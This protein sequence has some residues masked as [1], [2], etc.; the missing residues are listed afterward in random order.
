MI[1]IYEDSKVLFEKNE[2]RKVLLEDDGYVK[3]ILLDVEKRG[4]EA[5][6]EYTLN[7][8]G[9]NINN[10]LV[11][12]EEIVEAYENVDTELIEALEISAENI[13]D[14]HRREIPQSF[15]FEK[16]GI[17]AG[18]MIMPLD[19]TG[20]YVPGGRAAYPS[21]VLMAAIP[22]KICGV[23]RIVIVT[24]PNKNGKC[25][26]AVL[27]AS[28][29]AG[30]DEVYKVGGAQAIAAL[31]YGT[32][33]I[34]KVSKIV[35]PGNKYVAMAKKLV[36]TPTEFPAGPSEV[37]IIAEE[38]SN[39]RFIAL[40]MLAQSEHDP[41]ASAYLLTSSRNLAE[42][43]KGEIEKELMVL[44]RKNIL[45]E[46][47][48]RGGIFIISSI[49]EAIDLSNE[50]APE[51]LEIMINEPFSILTKI[52]N[53]GSVF[54]GDYSPEAMGDY[55]SGTNHVLPTSG[56][57]RYYSSLSVDDFLKKYTFQYITKDGLKTYRNT[58]SILAR[59]EGLFAHEKAVNVRFEDEKQI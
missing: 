8:D 54:L 50:F 13:E 16:K 48:K 22:P 23:P 38:S 56:Y 37:M 27:V 36:E 32:E 12:Q 24:P 53:A 5:L 40:D 6:R 9:V 28:D 46:S 47:L 25:N 35:G 17:T 33:S 52:K 2:Q 44:P 31:A 41:L 55:V 20:I 29:I 3:S 51:H 58:V 14:F 34:K 39:P 7:F 10:F 21:T 59:S 30:V 42:K 43:V 15:L 26:D 11:N 4:D 19:S 45:E 18:Q 49:D 1:E 57:A